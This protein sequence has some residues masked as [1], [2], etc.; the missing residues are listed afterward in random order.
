MLNDWSGVNNNWRLLGGIFPVGAPVSVVAR[1]PDQL[2]LFVVGNDG[3][4]YTSWWSAGRDWSGLNNNW[5]NIGGVFPVGGP[6]S[7]VAR[8]PNQLDLFVVGNNGG[9]YTSWWSAGHDWSGLNNNWRLIG[10][11]FRVG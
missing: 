4:V 5:R 8:K 3:R 1:N 7:A 9:V 11:I 2:D 6:V 10:G